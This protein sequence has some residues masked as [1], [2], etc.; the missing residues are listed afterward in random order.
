MRVGFY[1]T[2]AQPRWTPTM[3][4]SV[5]AAMPGVRLVQLT[6]ETSPAVSGVDVHRLPAAP[7]SLHR[8]RHFASLVGDWLLLDTDV[9]AQRDVRAVF[10][11]P[12]DVALADRQWTKTPRGGYRAG[13]QPEYVA[14]FPYN[15]GVVF[16]R[17]PA[18]WAEVVR[19]L[20]SR[21]AL[22]TS[23]TGDQEAICTLA[24]SGRYRV[25]V[26]PGMIYNF[27]PEGLDDPDTPR[28]ALVHYKG[29][30]RKPYLLARIAA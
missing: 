30:H 26:L 9:I 8:A 4:Q 25:K 10:A 19:Y 1:L 5:R 20:T 13:G 17:A 3:L 14:R 7:L 22:Q 2:G 12:F 28:A 6:D 15:A 11:D 27:P 16:S 23:W 24:A 18:F 21:P 29:K